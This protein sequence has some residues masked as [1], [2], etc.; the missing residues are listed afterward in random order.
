MSKRLI[1]FLVAVIAV[2]AGLAVWLRRGPARPEV[3]TAAVTRQAHFRSTVTASG[4]IVAHKYADIGT[5]VMGRVVRLGVA[6]GDRVRAGQVL[7]QI[8]PVPARADAASAAAQVEALDADERAAAEQV[9]A[10]GQDVAAA[11]A[12]ARDAA[13]QFDR[14]RALRDQQLVPAIELETA[15]AAYDE[16]RAAVA[17]ANAALARAREALVG[18]GRRAAQARAQKLRAD[19]VLRKTSIV[20]PMD[21][22]VSRLRVR[23]G[24]MVVFGIQNQPGTT[25]M[26]IS[27][28]SAV[29]AEVKVAEAD[30]VRL[31]VGQPADVTLEALSGRRLTGHVVEIGASA[32]PVAGTSAAAREFRVVIRLD[33]PDP[34]LRPGLTCDAEI[35]TAERDRALT[36]PLQSV[37]LRPAPGGGD[38]P[39]VFVL[40]GTRATFRP[41]TTGAIGGL[42]MEVDGLSEGTTVVSGPYQVLRDLQDG[43]VVRVATPR[44]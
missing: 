5:D 23:E 28:L 30:M 43:A 13:Q 12:R 21:G 20:A 41:V 29:N 37:V 36:V 39:G 16:A 44:G 42:D 17:S 32:L 35:V 7:A 18:A 2:V 10:A 1:L 31:R 38:R 6:E 34:A 24:E 11:D 19:D 14:K 25:L 22:I 9:R 27:D 40:D 15:R 26:T 4:E 33:S 8:D 3:D